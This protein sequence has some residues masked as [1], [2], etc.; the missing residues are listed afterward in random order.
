MS[1][2]K[3]TAVFALFAFLVLAPPSRTS[4]ARAQEKSAAPARVTPCDLNAYVVDH[5]P[6][7]LNVRSGPGSTFK[8]VGNLPNK[9]VEGVGVHI[10]GG[11]GE[12]VRIDRATE[13]GGDEDRTLFSG[14]GWVYGPLLGTDGVG[15]VEGGTP[16]YQEPSKKSRVLARMLA[17]AEGASV[18]GCKGKWMYVEHKKVKGWAQG[19]TLC[20]NSLTTCS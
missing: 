4:S 9:G 18:R 1:L 20:D 10:T 16:I 15:W 8:V 12:W 19:D 2:A 5:D 7:G 6:N 3:L 11:S 13:Q 17:G 14:E